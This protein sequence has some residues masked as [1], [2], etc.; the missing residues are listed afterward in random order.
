M[1]PA[2]H[3]TR[4]LD[5]A[6]GPV[7]RFR[8]SPAPDHHCGRAGH[9]VQ[10]SLIVNESEAVLSICDARANYLVLVVDDLVLVLVTG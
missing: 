3:D 8:G 6:E 5:K 4:L 9:R 10:L 2:A 7:P 1:W